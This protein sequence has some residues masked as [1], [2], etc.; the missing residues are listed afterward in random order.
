M[1]LSIYA[2]LLTSLHFAVQIHILHN[3]FW[4]CR[5]TDRQ[6]HMEMQMPTQ[7]HTLKC[8]ACVG[9]MLDSISQS[10]P[11][12]IPCSF[13]RHA[14]ST[15]TAALISYAEVLLEFLLSNIS[16][17]SFPF[18]SSLFL[19]CTHTCLFLWNGRHFLGWH[20]IPEVLLAAPCPRGNHC[21]GSNK[22]VNSARSPSPIVFWPL[23]L[24]KA[25]A[26]RCPSLS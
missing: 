16:L 7:T 10:C 6:T 2:V 12:Q 19:W 5:H 4:Y 20:I 22:S 3:L 24:Y 11:G 14:D 9:R 18:F 13:H 23:L 26:P 17:V 8:Y 21:S 25:W 1:C 15:K